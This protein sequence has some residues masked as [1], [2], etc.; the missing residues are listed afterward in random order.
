MQTISFPSKNNY[1]QLLT[2]IFLF[3]ETAKLKQTN[4]IHFISKY[5][6]LEIANNNNPSKTS[7]YDPTWWHSNQKQIQLRLPPCAGLQNIQL[8]PMTHLATHHE[9][10][11]VTKLWSL[12]RDPPP[13][14][15]NNRKS[16]MARSISTTKDWTRHLLS[17]SFESRTV[18]PLVV[19]KKRQK[20]LQS[21]TKNI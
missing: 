16:W 17:T 14:P 10:S 12:T 15:K 2:K 21:K 19:Q 20:G 4:K 11:D 9:F 7:N 13:P 5:N 8:R 18:Q 6:N 3:S 1:K